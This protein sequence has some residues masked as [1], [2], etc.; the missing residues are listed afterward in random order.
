MGF[1]PAAITLDVREQGWAA[2]LPV[3]PGWA[4][5]LAAARATLRVL[6]AEP[7]AEP[8]RHLLS[9]Y[10]LL[11]ASSPHCCAPTH[12][13]SQL[14][15]NQMAVC[16]PEQSAPALMVA[17]QCPGSPFVATSPHFA[18]PLLTPAALLLSRCLLKMVK[19]NVVVPE[20]ILSFCCNGLQVPRVLCQ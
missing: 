6:C 1:R 3:P 4:V 2:A 19:G 13:L 9:V 12:G 10:K 16:I 5:G 18:I 17:L 20:D 14:F 11:A 7:C 8:C 15:P